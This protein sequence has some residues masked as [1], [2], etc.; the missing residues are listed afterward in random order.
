MANISDAINAV[1]QVSKKTEK[2]NTEPQNPNVNSI[3]NTQGNETMDPMTLAAIIYGIGTIISTGISEYQYEDSKDFQRENRDYY[4]E[5]NVMSRMMA[6]GISPAAAA[7]GIS[8]GRGEQGVSTNPYATDFSKI[9]DGIFSARK[10]EFENQL[11]EAQANKANEETKW[12]PRLNLATEAEI[13]SR[14]DLNYAQKLNLM[15]QNRRIQGE[16]KRWQKENNYTDKQIEVQN[17]ILKWYDKKTQT[18]I[19]AM[20]SQI[21]K[22]TKEAAVLDEQRKKEFWTNKFRDDFGFDPH[23]SVFS[24]CVQAAVNGKMTNIINGITNSFKDAITST[25]DNTGNIFVDGWNDF[26]NWSDRQ[27]GKLGNFVHN[28]YF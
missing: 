24:Q 2:S 19:D 8:G 10:M 26:N 1:S 21:Y 9:G 16:L 20:N 23:D 18:E 12:I 6:A 14:K 13:N 22:W 3:Q 27:F 15:Y 11:L 28:K 5:S 7:Q 17:K 25:I 4:N